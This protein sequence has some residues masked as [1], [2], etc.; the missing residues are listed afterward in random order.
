VELELSPAYRRRLVTDAL[1]ALLTL[2]PGAP[3]VLRLGDLLTRFTAGVLYVLHRCFDRLCLVR[4]PL[5]SCAAESEKFV[6]LWGCCP[7]AERGPAAD[8]LASLLPA[9][10]AAEARGV[11]TTEASA[12]TTPPASS[13]V[14]A[15][16]ASYY[17]ADAVPPPVWA[18]SDFYGYVA[19][20]ANEMARREVRALQ[21]LRDHP[22]PSALRARGASEA[23]RQRVREH[24]LAVLSEAGAPA[25]GG[26]SGGGGGGGG[27]EEP[28]RAALWSRAP[29]VRTFS[30]N[31][32]SH[33]LICAEVA[34][35]RVM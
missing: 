5:G 14:P 19:G 6:I 35:C 3:A 21:S 23:Y 17:L 12:A 2:A 33:I 15:V 27:G 31:S 22:A 25:A 26:G 11:Q 9:L 20:R 18:G 32:V 8:Y 29:A 16:N 24:A 30:L 4:S 10:A 28:G 13:S 7:E 34:I 1:L